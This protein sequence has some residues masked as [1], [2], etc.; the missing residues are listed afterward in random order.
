MLM[1]RKSVASS[2]S[3]SATL[4]D[5]QG[6][7]LST[8]GELVVAHGVLRE[9]TTKAPCACRGNAAAHRLCEPMGRIRVT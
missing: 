7:V 8:T 5:V 3:L 6:A 9:P 2:R 4:R 1:C